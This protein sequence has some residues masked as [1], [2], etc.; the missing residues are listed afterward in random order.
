MKGRKPKPS[1]L[2]LIE[3]NPGGR[4]LPQDEP[5]P[6]VCLPSCPRWLS[7][8]AKREWRRLGPKLRAA[9]VVTELDGTALAL[10]CQTWARWKEA[11][12]QVDRFG[13]VLRGSHGQLM[14]SPYGRIAA[15]AADQLLRLLVEFGMTPSS[16]S[17]VHGLVSPAESD[18]VEEWLKNGK[19]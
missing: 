1:V 18:P 7:V 19:H 8:E 5:R 16:R 13:A 6:R 15:Q 9:G 17:R 12:D 2:R 4:P 10:L 11:E 3:G 14:R